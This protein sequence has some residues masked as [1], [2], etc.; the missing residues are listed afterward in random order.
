MP[1]L[2]VHRLASSLLPVETICGTASAEA[3]GVLGRM[4]ARTLGLEPGGT[5]PA[6]LVIRPVGGRERWTRRFGGSVWSTTVRRGEPSGLVER[7]G[8]F[9]V[10]FEVS[11]GEPS[12]ER[13]QHTGTIVL[14]STRIGVGPLPSPLHRLV[15]VEARLASAETI[16]TIDVAGG[17]VGSCSYR[18]VGRRRADTIRPE[19]GRR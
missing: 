10:H 7:V 4:L 15:R 17:V 16:V 3:H 6:S 8:P 1:V 14:R 19:R 5:V 18:F 12:G 13:G 9:D 2:P 11:V